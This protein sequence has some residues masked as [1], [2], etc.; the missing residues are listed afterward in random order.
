MSPVE[1]CHNSGE[2]LSVQDRLKEIRQV[3]E[4]E[5]G[6]SI[7]FMYSIHCAYEDAEP[8]EIT[9]E[10]GTNCR[11]I[12]L[13][14]FVRDDASI[15]EYF[16]SKPPENYEMKVDASLDD[17]ATE[18]LSDVIDGALKKIQSI[19]SGPDDGQRSGICVAIYYLDDP[20]RPDVY[21]G[22]R[23][24]NSLSDGDTVGNHDQQFETIVALIKNFE[25][26][27]LEDLVCSHDRYNFFV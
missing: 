23:Q 11:P 8:Y 10:V 21:Y 5:L 16:E 13:E 27:Y 17:L 20:F 24:V 14:G 2:A 4:E 7:P 22:K 18:G 1:Q 26:D 19:I 3:L 25:M 9:T 6:M 15:N 12:Y